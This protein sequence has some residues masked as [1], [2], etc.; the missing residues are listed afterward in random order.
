MIQTQLT[1]AMIQANMM[2]LFA[3]MSISS[4]S[5]FKEV[6]CFVPFA[7]SKSRSFSMMPIHSVE[8][9]ISGVTNSPPSKPLLSKELGKTLAAGTSLQDKELACVYKAS[10]DGWSA[11]DFHQSV[12][13]KGSALVVALSR[14]G[15]VFGGFNPLGWRS[16]DDYYQSNAAFLWFATSDQKATRCPILTGGKWS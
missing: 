13:G 2:M 16:T 14:S 3:F 1:R 11:L 12:D 15:Q 9:W 4:S 5:F 8:N 6:S 10:K 7:T